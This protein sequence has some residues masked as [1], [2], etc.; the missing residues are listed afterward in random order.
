MSLFLSLLSAIAAVAPPPVEGVWVDKGLPGDWA[1]TSAVLS[2]AGVD[3]VLPCLLY[4]VSPAYPSSL[5]PVSE[6]FPPDTGWAND[7]IAECGARGIEVHAWVILWKANR[8][9][10]VFLDSLA[11][12]GRLQ[13]DCSGDTLPWLCPTDPRNLALEEALVLELLDRFPLDGVQFDYVRFPGAES[14]CCQGCRD[15]FARS[16]GLSPGAW[17]EDVLPG[18]RFHREFGLWRADRITHALVLLSMAAGGRGAAVSAA[19]LPD[20]A[21]ALGCGQDW[22]LWGRSGVL[23]RIYFMNYFRTAA[24]LDSVISGQADGLTCG[25]PAV[26]GLGTGIG[27]LEVSPEEARRQVE[28][29]IGAGF[30]GVCHFHLNQTLLRTLASAP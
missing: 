7:L 16:T 27:R 23:D 21:D 13:V 12:E 19:V 10:G 14:C 5:V 11:R 20:R 8:A 18:G 9:D 29:A 24:E 22:S 3:H 1:G 2:E 30:S 4:G 25:T 6:A 17:P 28:T 15:R 26:C